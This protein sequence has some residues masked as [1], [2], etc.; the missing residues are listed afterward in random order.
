MTTIP[1]VPK[2]E[3]LR[4]TLMDDI[5][6]LPPHAPLP[7]ERNLSDTYNV[8]RDTVRKALDWLHTS[9]AIYR[10]QGAGTFV[11]G[12]TITKTLSLSSFTRDMIDRGMEPSSKLLA[13]DRRAAGRVIGEQ[14]GVAESDEVVRVTRV[15]LA[16]A[17]PICLETTHIVGA[18]VPGLMDADLTESLYAI[19]DTRYSLR[20][21]RAEQIVTAVAV[22]EIEAALL[23]IPT[24]SAAMHVHRI[25]MDERDS[26][27]ESTTTIYRGDMYDLRFA[28]HRH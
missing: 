25:G 6:G 12:M 8:S 13:M 26:P 3:W 5:R 18:L 20:V 9:G 14:L 4:A 23:A 19:L 22:S 16:N 21:M 24:H 15:R 17:R 27:I 1:S 2:H 28:V 10:V 11:A 7:T